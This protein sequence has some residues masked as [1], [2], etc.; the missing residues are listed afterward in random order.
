M[1]ADYELELDEAYLKKTPT[2]YIY[3]SQEKK[4]S[5]HL[6]GGVYILRNLLGEDPPKAIKM[7]LEWEQE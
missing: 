2:R 5:D 7:S 6:I 4:G 3:R 1:R